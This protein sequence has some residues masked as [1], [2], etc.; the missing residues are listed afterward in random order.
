MATALDT[1]R[2]SEVKPLVR[3]NVCL[4]VDPAG[5]AAETARWI[6]ETRAEFG[7]RGAFDR[8]R[9]RG[10]KTVLVVGCSTGYGLASRAAA[11]ACGASTIGVSFEREPD[12]SRQGSP[13][14]YANRAFER[15]AERSGAEAITIEGDAFSREIKARAIAAIR[16]SGRTV[17]LLVYSLASP[18]RA[19]ADSGKQWRSTLKPIG[20]AYSAKTVDMGSGAFGAVTIQPAN[21]EE[22]EATVK[23]MGGE[24]WAEWIRALSGAG[25]LSK[26][27]I[28][29]AYSYIGPELTRPIY[30]EGT[31]GRA[32]EHLEATARRINAESPD[33]SLRAYVSVQKALVTRASAV[34]P[35][36]PLYIS[37]LYKVMKERGTHEDCVQQIVRLFADRLYGKAPLELDGEGRIRLDDLEMDEA[38]Q[39]EVARRM[40]D[41]NADNAGKLLDVAGFR[42]DFLRA[43]GFCAGLD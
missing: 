7:K 25:A 40:A 15:E 12:G 37:A 41:A 2:D 32:K 3:N 14:W 28:S 23:V 34:I 42:E 24:D 30:R 17:D 36:I 9:A 35:V 4:N 31:I 1:K 8:M 13:G 16:A 39:E 10:P 22:V 5:C 20:R 21:E 43:H 11:M 26:G 33:G 29:I 38:T 18:V 19:D 27:A 6:A